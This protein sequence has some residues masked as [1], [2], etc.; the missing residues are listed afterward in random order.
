MTCSVPCAPG[1]SWTRLGDTDSEAAGTVDEETVDEETVDGVFVPAPAEA[2]AG[3]DTKRR[4]R[5]NGSAKRTP[6]VIG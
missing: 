1:T 5:R 3:T 4:A 2:E 6:K